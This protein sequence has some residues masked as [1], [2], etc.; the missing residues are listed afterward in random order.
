MK[1]KLGDFNSTNNVK[2][3]ILLIP[4]KYPIN[5]T[6]QVYFNDSFSHCFWHQKHKKRIPCQ[7]YRSFYQHDFPKHA[8]I[9]T[10]LIMLLGLQGYFN[11]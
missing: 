9:S 4:L 2:T 5:H 11:A 1:Q 7:L 10:V 3:L 8:I 6:P